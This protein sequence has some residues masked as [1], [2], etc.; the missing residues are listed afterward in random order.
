MSTPIFLELSDEDGQQTIDYTNGLLRFTQK[1]SLKSL[2][3]ILADAHGT[4]SDY[5]IVIELNNTAN[6]QS[7]TIR[8]L[9]ITYPE[10]SFI[11]KSGTKNWLNL[12]FEFEESIAIDS[13]KDEENINLMS[14]VCEILSSTDDSGSVIDENSSFLKENRE[15]INT[16]PSQKEDYSPFNKLID[17]VNKGNSAAFESC[18]NMVKAI[19]EDLELISNVC[20]VLSSNTN[21]ESRCFIETSKEQLGRICGCSEYLPFKELC[22]KISTGNVDF[23]LELDKCQQMLEQKQEE[24]DL[25][26]AV[27]EIFMPLHDQVDITQNYISIVKSRSAVLAELRA[28]MKGKGELAD[29]VYWNRLYQPFKKLVDCAEKGYSDELSLCKKWICALCVN[30]SMHAFTEDYHVLAER[31]N[32]FDASN[33]RYAVKLFVFNEKKV[34]QNNAHVLESRAHNIAY[35][36]DEESAQCR[37][38]SYCLYANG[39]RAFPVSTKKLLL[40]ASKQWKGQHDK[41]ILRD[42][43]LQFKDEDQGRNITREH[44]YCETD[45]IRG[46]KYNSTTKKW[47][48]LI[49]ETYCSFDDCAISCDYNPYWHK[50]DL[51]YTYCVSQGYSGLDIVDSNKCDGWKISDDK[52][53][54]KVPGA[55]K[56]VSGIYKELTENISPIK[57]CFLHKFQDTDIDLKRINREHSTPLG[58]YDIALNIFRRAECYLHEHN[59]VKAAVLSQE[60]IEILNGYHTSLF[61]QAYHIHAQAENAI[62]M[63]MLGCD[64]SSIAEDCQMRVDIIRHDINRMLRNTT[65]DSKNILN[66][67]YADCRQYCHEKEHFQSEEVFIDAMAK[68][69]DGIDSKS[70]SLFMK[71][72]KEKLKSP[73]KLLSNVKNIVTMWCTDTI[74][75]IIEYGEDNK[76]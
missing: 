16:V 67:I 33:L 15:R 59:Y 26:G 60:A 13:F 31:E 6:S 51:K 3:H 39:M 52:R 75:T 48:N 64:E 38:L 62:A 27:C 74:N 18:I 40:Y 9:I 42:F 44:G 11:F 66:Q 63:N 43:D 49:S 70:P 34:K 1:V 25:M 54:L 19:R 71:D 68:L 35:V 46:Y 47:E 30:T 8:N 72:A 21:E 24:V 17:R 7:A 5:H 23:S 61:L 29:N 2:E 32:L 53:R 45:F 50:E 57:K 55:K 69:N 73:K 14:K 12:L 28:F 65:F 4:L 22:D 20:G 56:P 76:E 36:V 58:L 10:V 37:Q 41:I